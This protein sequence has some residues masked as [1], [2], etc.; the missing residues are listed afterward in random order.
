M[1]VP[2]SALLLRKPQA[3]DGAALHA[4]IEACPPLDLN[5]VYCYLLQCSHFA[6]TSVVAERAGELVGAI[7]GYR[8]PA[9]GDTLFI[10]QVAVSDKARG[11]G[12]A[13]RMLNHIVDGEACAGVAF[14]ET[15]VTDDNRASW[16]LFESFARQREAPL[17]RSLKFD[18]ETHFLGAHD[19]E[20]L[21]RIGPFQR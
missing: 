16:A 13:R 20:Y 14:M 19:S 21:A 12:L 3:Q 9:Q 17:Q 7:T 5:S 4:L 1:N 10:W 2:K 18:R 11:E 6:A 8:P 15:T